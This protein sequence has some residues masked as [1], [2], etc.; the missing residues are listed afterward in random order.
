LSFID[1]A[2]PALSSSGD[3]ILEPEDSLD[4]DLLSCVEDCM[5]KLALL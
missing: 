4:N 2:N 1:T 3:V 5:S